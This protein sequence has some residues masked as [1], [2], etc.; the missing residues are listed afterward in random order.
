MKSTT[1]PSDPRTH[2]KGPWEAVRS[3]TCGHLRAAHNY[4]ENP[5]EEWTND[6][7]A[8]ISA[9]PDLLAALRAIVRHQEGAA[10]SMARYSTTRI[11]A[12]QA[13]ARAGFDVMEAPGKPEA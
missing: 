2:T 4:Q 13:I 12:T 1:K 11:I 8:L 6:D 7:L 9:A 3:L 10:G 5:K